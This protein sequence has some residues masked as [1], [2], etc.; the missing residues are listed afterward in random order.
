MGK[1][2][3]FAAKPKKANQAPKAADAWVSSGDPRE[4]DEPKNEAPVAMK[5]LTIDV[6]ADLHQR[7]KIGCTKRGLKMADAIRNLL[8]KEF[9]E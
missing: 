4:Q 1:K 3:S 2:I 7:I 5:R 9:P 6:P 8:D